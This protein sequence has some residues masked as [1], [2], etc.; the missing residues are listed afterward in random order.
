MPSAEVAP[1]RTMTSGAIAAPSDA[2]AAADGMPVTTSPTTPVITVA[3]RR[4]VV[5]RIVVGMAA[6]DCVAAL[7]V[8]RD[9]RQLLAPPTVARRA[10]A[11]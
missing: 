6:S 10:G 7:L 8:R 5:L 1:G 3:R 2:V 11:V 9:G 4:P